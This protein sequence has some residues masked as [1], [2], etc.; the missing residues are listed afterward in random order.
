MVNSSKRL[1]WKKE[2]DFNIGFGL[3]TGQ[4]LPITPIAVEVGFTER[5]EDLVDDVCGWLRR[6]RQLSIS[7]LVNI[8][9]DKRA[10]HS[11]QSSDKF[12]SRASKL[13]S[14]YGNSLGQ[15]EKGIYAQEPLDDNESDETMYDN[16]DAN[17]IDSDWVGPL[18]ASIEI[19]SR[20]SGGTPYCREGPIVRLLPPYDV[21]AFAN[22]FLRRK[23]FPRPLQTQLSV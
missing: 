1:A 6:Y 7:I 12:F 2:S 13:L 3:L 17:I 8:E 5:Y 22:P 20:T 16:I 15:E 23:S 18:P 9:E 21:E 10:L 14:Q 19:W 4:S 11:I